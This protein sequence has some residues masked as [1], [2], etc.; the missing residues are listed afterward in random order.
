MVKQWMMDIIFDFIST[1]WS[2]FESHCESFGKGIAKE[3]YIALGGSP[4]D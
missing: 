3:I 4:D 2:A 1:N